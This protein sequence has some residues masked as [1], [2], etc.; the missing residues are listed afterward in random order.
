MRIGTLK[1]DNIFF[2]APLAGI[3]DRVFRGLVKR[4]G[5]G[6]VFSE[7]INTNSVLKG[8][9]NLR[10]FFHSPRYSEDM[11]ID[12]RAGN[13]STLKKNSYKILHDN[14][15]R[16]KLQTF[17]M[18]NLIVNDPIKAKH[19]E[20]TQRFKLKIITSSGESLPTKIEF[21]RRKKTHDLCTYKLDRV[22]TEISHRY[23]RLSFLCQHYT[24][25]A[26]IIQKIEALSG[27]AQA[28]SRDVFDIFILMLGG[29]PKE[30]DLSKLDPKLITKSKEA[31]LLLNYTDFKGQ[32]L[33]FLN[34][35]EYKKYSKEEN[36]N[37]MQKK[38]IGL[39]SI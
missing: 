27:R 19:T 36:W 4:Y 12:V 25:S 14:G 30:L 26:A 32:V 3:T 23:K 35:E 2:L 17:G 6:L 34:E 7:M 29:Y 37:E 20:T 39:L 9:V 10:F 13:V 21:S 38:V 31:V 15:F 11:D 8:G 33:E 18:D 28:Q 22:N 5:C 1:L 16:R 24:G